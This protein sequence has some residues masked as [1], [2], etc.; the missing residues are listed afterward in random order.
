MSS[1]IKKNKEEDHNRLENV[2]KERGSKRESSKK[3]DFE[4]KEGSTIYIFLPK[5][6]ISI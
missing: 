3:Q 1:K 2:S 5:L 6:Y 4:K